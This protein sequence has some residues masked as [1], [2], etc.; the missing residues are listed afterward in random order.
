MKLFYYYDKKADVF[1]LSQGKPSAQD[2]TKELADDVVIRINPRTKKIR[3]FTI[4]NFASRLR[5]KS[6]PLSLPIR[7]ELTPA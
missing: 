3:G 5:K 4:L 2:A 7:A 6:L 1:Y